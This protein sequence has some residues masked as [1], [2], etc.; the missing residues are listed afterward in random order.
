MILYHVTHA[1]NLVS[2]RK[3]GL[4]PGH[5]PLGVDAAR[6][7]VQDAVFFESRPIA[8][9]PGPLVFLRL[10]VPDDDLF[11]IADAYPTDVEGAPTPTTW[12]GAWAAVSPGCIEA[13]A[14]PPRSDTA[15]LARF[16][17]GAEKALAQSGL[18]H[19]LV[20]ATR[21][22]AWRA[23]RQFQ[24]LTSATPWRAQLELNRTIK[25][26]FSKRS[27]YDL[28]LDAVECHVKEMHHAL[29]DDAPWQAVWRGKTRGLSQVATRQTARW[30]TRR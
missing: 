20:D 29:G 11:C 21:R 30:P 26:R 6:G 2:I 27:C 9:Q 5:S 19:A 15:H 22:Y 10:D 7:I 18:P 4:L 8:P 1:R 13:I 3:Q 24:A 23:V 16:I 12:R 25:W 28:F 14:S 17:M